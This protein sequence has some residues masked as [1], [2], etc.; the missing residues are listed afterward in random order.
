MRYIPKTLLL[1]PLFTHVALSAASAPLEWP[2]TSG[3]HPTIPEYELLRQRWETASKTP[4]GQA[5][6]NDSIRDAVLQR[7][8]LSN[9]SVRELRW[10]SPT[11]VMA[12]VFWHTEGDHGR[13]QCVL[14]RHGEQ[15]KVI[16]LYTISVS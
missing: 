10:L 5:E 2:S 1:I 6:D 7:I 12:L 13:L 11:L 15:W 3:G 9:T 14:E 8:T 16:A 4:L